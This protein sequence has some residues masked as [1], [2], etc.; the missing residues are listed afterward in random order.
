[1]DAAKK[2]SPP[3]ASPLEIEKKRKQISNHV[4][5][6]KKSADNSWK[7]LLPAFNDVVEL[8]YCHIV[9]A[10]YIVNSYVVLYTVYRML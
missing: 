5:K 2:A 3:D 9:S 4:I 1:M 7:S 10:M 6:F 8:S